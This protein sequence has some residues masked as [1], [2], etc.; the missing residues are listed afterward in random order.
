MG[1]AHRPVLRARGLYVYGV[2]GGKIECGNTDEE[3]YFVGYLRRLAMQSLLQ[4]LPGLCITL[5][6][7]KSS[8]FSFQILLPVCIKPEGTCPSSKKL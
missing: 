8:R 6:Q 5:F 3:M 1:D 7:P 2:Q 4:R